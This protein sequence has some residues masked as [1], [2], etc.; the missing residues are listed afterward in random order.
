MCVVVVVNS[1]DGNIWQ[2]TP[3][4]NQHQQI[5]QECNELLNGEPLT[6][7]ELLALGAINAAL[8]TGQIV[9]DTF[10]N[11]LSKGITN[12]QHNKTTT[13]N[14]DEI[15]IQQ[16]PDDDF[17][18]CADLWHCE[19]EYKNEKRSKLYI[20]SCLIIKGTIKFLKCCDAI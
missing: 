17:S 4:I 12:R 18:C 8:P 20:V 19:S 1:G 5:A 13:T 10:F 11:S 3:M 6:C 2:Q 16:L 14:G 15:Y 9:L 7:Q